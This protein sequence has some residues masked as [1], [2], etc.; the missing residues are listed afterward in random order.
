M[1]KGM[2]KEL[3]LFAYCYLPYTVENHVESNNKKMPMKPVK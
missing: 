3:S 2:L 1:L